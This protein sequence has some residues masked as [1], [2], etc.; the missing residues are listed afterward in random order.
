MDLPLEGLK[1]LDLSR[2]LPGPLCTCFL[3]DLGASITKVEDTHQG[4][5]A[6]FYPPLVKN[7]SNFFLM[8]NRN[9]KS[10]AINLKKTEGI[11]ILKKLI[12]ENDVLIDSFR[13]GVLEKMGLSYEIIKQINPS[14]VVCN[15][16]GFGNHPIYKNKAGHDLNFIGLAG[17][18]VF[19]QNDSPVVPP[20]QIADIVGGALSAALKIVAASYQS[21]KNKKGCFIN[22]SMVENLGAA[23]PFNLLESISLSSA[24]HYNVVELLTGKSPFYTYY[25]TSDNKFVAFAPVEYKFWEAF[26]IA[27]K[28]ND[29][30]EF[31]M[32]KS[33]GLKS[34]IQNHIEK[35][36]WEFWKQFS[37]EN[38]CCVSPV[39]DNLSASDFSLTF[40]E[41]HPIEGKV[42]HQKSILGEN[43]IYQ[44]AP[45]WGEHTVEILKNIGFEADKI[46]ELKENKVIKVYQ[47]A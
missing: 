27:T 45:Q 43:K 44:A 7:N 34:K 37:I 8:L 21:L 6:R 23:F 35:H 13:P 42:L 28:N 47:N 18:T 25:K 30:T 15:L 9:K 2:L 29:W 3:G 20:F 38:D 5:Y 39:Y 40:S 41:N 10:V 36:D 4:D 17:L 31:Y 22:H 26:C 33:E 32:Q 1:V 12:A 11:E 24:T 46:E 19:D 16:N 14:M